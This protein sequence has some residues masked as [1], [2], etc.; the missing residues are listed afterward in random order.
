[1]QLVID[2]NVYIF[3][4]GLVEVPSCKE[5]ILTI[6]EKPSLYILRISR[7]IVE[8]IRR[9]LS[10]EDFHEFITI[11][12]RITKVDED[13]LI[14]FELGAKYEIKGLKPSDAL[15]A[16]YVEW[17]GA[18]VLVT[19]NRHFLSRQK[20]LSFKVINAEGCLKILSK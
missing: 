15:I 2:A 19:E 18:D 9:H 14:P 1:M 17:I 20:D 16:A 13:F 3:G 7:N 5:L 12:N 11:V 10:P 4:L 8:E 6:L